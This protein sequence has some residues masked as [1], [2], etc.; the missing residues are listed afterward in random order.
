MIMDNIF[1]CDL[2]GEGFIRSEA[3]KRHTLRHKIN[4]GT[5]TEEE[6]N[7]LELQKKPC[8]FCGRKFG[9]PSALSRHLKSH[10]GIKDYVCSECGKAFTEKRY[11]DDHYNMVHLGLMNY[12]CEHCGKPFGR[13][14]T[15][16]A[17]MKQV[18]GKTPPSRSKRL[19]QVRTIKVFIKLENTISSFKI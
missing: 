12:P 7:Q 3:F 18:H 11:R 4:E 8:E 2:C 13:Y 1:S 10:M 16:F 6:K 14:N 17:H 5:L 15:L 19:P 9:D